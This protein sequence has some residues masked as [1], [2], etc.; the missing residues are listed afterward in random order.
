MF[1]PDE[2]LVRR[3]K[4][5][6][7]EACVILYKKYTNKILNYIYRYVNDYQ[8]AE[9][10]TILTFINMLKNIRDYKERG[11][12]SAWLYKIAGNCAKRELEN[13]A[14]KNE[15]SLDTDIAKDADTE[16]ER[17]IAFAE[18][19]KDE[20]NRPDRNTEESELK[21]LI[22][23]AVSRLDAKLRDV[24]LLC[25]IDGV[26]YKEAAK[27]LNTNAITV[28]TRLMRARAMLYNILK[29]F[30]RELLQ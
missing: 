12:F 9:D 6:D 7:E 5:G 4:D 18:F 24:L 22:H 15:V 26:P 19:L 8:K 29:R 14:R 3:I 23:N 16:G 30:K 10:L 13:K 1:P 11:F 2:E 21:E 27:I 17:P 25:D 20:T 28:G